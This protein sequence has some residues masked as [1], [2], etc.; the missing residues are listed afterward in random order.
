MPARSLT[1]VLTLAVLA[2]LSVAARSE[3]QSC[4]TDL[5]RKI[6]QS[7]AGVAGLTP[8]QFQTMLRDPDLPPPL[9]LD[10]REE[11]EFA[12]SHVPGAERVDPGIDADVF[13]SRFGDG[14]AGRNVIVYCS[15][16]VRSSRLAQRIEAAARRSGAKGV[17]NLRGG[18]FAWHNYGLA[19]KAAGARTDL[20]HPFSRSWAYYLDFPNYS[21]LEPRAGK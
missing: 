9:V 6:E 14:L 10:V 21:R 2:G 1:I 20:V 17:F 18:I 4:L 7:H 12:V 19:L 3:G 5:E 15:V 16:G 13:M 11:S 8:Q